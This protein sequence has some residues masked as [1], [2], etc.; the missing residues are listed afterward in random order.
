MIEKVDSALIKRMFLNKRA[1]PSQNMLTTY[2]F[3][4]INIQPV[5]Q[6]ENIVVQK[7]KT[8]C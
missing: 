7:L 1:H 6:S 3:A 2:L 5:S 8:C 4:V